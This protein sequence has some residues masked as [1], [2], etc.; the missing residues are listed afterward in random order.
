MGCGL[1]VLGCGSGSGSGSGSRFSV[2]GSIIHHSRW[3]TLV[4]SPT[5]IYSTTD[6]NKSTAI[7]F[8]GLYRVAQNQEG[9]LFVGI[10]LCQHWGLGVIVQVLCPLRLQMLIVLELEH[11]DGRSA[12]PA[13]VPAASTII[14]VHP[15]GNQ[16]TN[17]S[18]KSC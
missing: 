9:N 10:I 11:N 12:P 1:L 13:I 15:Q 6:T 18:E 17:N 7:S 4:L 8:W 16:K 2:L 5:V 3:Q 14:P